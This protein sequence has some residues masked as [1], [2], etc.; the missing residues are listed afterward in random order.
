MKTLS[1]ALFCLAATVSMTARADCERTQ[2]DYD[3]VYCGTKLYLEADKELNS[4]YKRL[5]GSLN[6]QGKQRLKMS[7]REWISSRNRNCSE[8]KGDQ[9]L[10]DLDCATSTT[11]ERTHFLDDRYR[12]CASTGCMNGKL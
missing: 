8:R 4:A 7:Q 9:I 12:E 10:V 11:V 3:V 1:L 6:D 2:T 5:R